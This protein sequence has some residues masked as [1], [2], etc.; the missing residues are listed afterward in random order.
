M[1]ELDFL[2]CLLQENQELAKEIW[3]N[4]NNKVRKILSRSRLKNHYLRLLSLNEPNHSDEINQ[5]LEN[6]QIKQRL[7]QEF[8]AKL[9]TELRC[10]KIN[11]IFFKGSIFSS[12][13][14]Q[15]S[16]DRYFS[17]FDVLIDINDIEKVYNFLD[18]KKY[19]HLR[20]YKYINRVGFCRTALEVINT[21]FGS[22]DLHHRIFSKFFMDKCQI[23]LDA[24]KEVHK[25][26]EVNH[27]SDE[28]NLCI[29]LYHACEQDKLYIDPYYLIDFFLIVKLKKLNNKK[30]FDFLEKYKL[31]D[32]FNFCEEAIKKLMNNDINFAEDLFNNARKS[33]KVITN[34][35]L[36][37]QICELYDPLPYMYAKTRKVDFNYF[38][39]LALKFE[40]FS[41]SLKQ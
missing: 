16:S 21:D 37:A 8:A 38:D 26:G 15:N 39:F 23:S 29:L 41:K 33:K 18:S 5:Y 32:H 4:D 1:T 27:A 35:I 19:N 30:L 10:N 12:L 24:F 17:D 7:K 20:N 6:E 3:I 31:E 11:H 9:S 34:N 25:H 22:I 36:K 13:Y 14:Y 40:K 28:I 2:K